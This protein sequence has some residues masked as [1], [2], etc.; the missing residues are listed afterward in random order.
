MLIES[1][2]LFGPWLRLESSVAA[3]LLAAAGQSMQQ[4]PRAQQIVTPGEVITTEEGFMRYVHLWAVRYFPCA[5]GGLLLTL[6]TIA[7]CLCLALLTIGTGSRLP[8]HWS[9]PLSSSKFSFQPRF[10]QHQQWS[11][12]ILGRGQTGSVGGWSSGENQQSHQC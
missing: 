8:V 1:F 10:V 12:H 6:P 2:F 5:Q 9:M 4:V 11:R 3:R 7:C